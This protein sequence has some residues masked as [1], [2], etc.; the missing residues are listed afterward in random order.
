MT[1]APRDNIFAD[2]APAYW[3]RRLSVVP[4]EPGEKRPAKELTNWQGYCS[5][6]PADATKQQWLQ[7][8]ADRNI[9]LLTNTA[10]TPGFKLGAIDVDRDAFVR[11][12][13]AILGSPPSRKKGKKGETFFVRVQD[14]PS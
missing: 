9:G 12:V 6:L 11:V 2:N 14:T 7:R 4:G 3:E 13:S 8:Y 5:N 10:L 1:D